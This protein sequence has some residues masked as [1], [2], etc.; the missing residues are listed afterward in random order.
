MTNSWTDLENAN[1]F[2][3]AGSNAAENHP[4][5]MKYL[6]RAQAKG[7]KIVVVDPRF[8]RT[9]AK[10]DLFAQI[11]PGTDIAYLGAIISYILENNRYDKEYLLNFTNASCR[12]NPNFA[13]NEGLFSGFD[14]SK[15]SYDMNTWGYVLDENGRPAKA[16]S[17]DESGTVFS[18]MKQ[19]FSRYTLETA[20]AISGIP[21]DT[22]RQIADIITK[23]GPGTIMYALG[24]TQHTTATQGIRCYAI[25]QLLLGNIGKCGG[26]VNALRG[27]PNVQGS[28][29]LSNLATTLPGYIP[30]PFDV[31]TDTSVYGQKYSST[32]RKHLISIL[33]AWFGDYATEANDYCYEYLPR[34]QSG[35]AITYI[36]MIEDMAR[37]QFKLLISTA[38]NPMVSV[39]NNEMVATG[40]SK[41][42][43]LV[44]LELFET[45]TAAFW[46][47]PNVKPEEIQTEVICLPAAFLYEKAGSFTNSGRWIQWKTAPLKPEGSAHSDLDIFTMIFR[48]VRELYADSTDPKDLPILRA[49]WDY[50][51]E[52]DPAKVLQE[53]NG[54]NVKSGKLIASLGEYLA[55]PIGE[56]S[57]GCWI[58]S[59]V[60]GSGNL[61]ARR[62]GEDPSGL[63]LFPGWTYSWPGN[64]RILYNRASCDAQGRP[65]DAKHQL[66]AWDTVK[67]QWGGN[68]IPDVI[69]RTKG[70]DTPEGKPAFR[71]TAEQMG[72]LFT[73]PYANKP[74]GAA[75]PTV[76]SGTTPDGPL[77]EFYEPMES[78]TGN[79]LHPKVAT[80]PVAQARRGLKDKPD[81]GGSDQFPYV[82]T[83]YTDGCEHF[84]SGSLSRNLPWLVECMPEAFLEIGDVLAKKLGIKNGEIV[85][86]LSARNSLQVMAMVTERI[87]PLLINGKE[88]HTV[89]MP[90]GWGFA[91]LATG[92]SVNSLTHGALDPAAGTPEYKAQLVNVR[93]VR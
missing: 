74:V 53:I 48:K 75:M 65:L 33:K 25:I 27:E 90:Y 24:M 7:A 91:G 1:W 84:C 28:T 80:N 18:L 93:K 58:Y 89:G 46:K 63:G 81:L 29:D 3:V 66:I 45:E 40:L 50:G 39:P 92:P 72:R 62:G 56:V 83:S 9:A 30:T 82:L 68:D 71:M 79:I 32:Y 64:I 11:R 70:P 51:E 76:V 55:A 22:I 41:L 49:S 5:A 67:G 19:H 88:T 44:N 36:P 57:C 38:I 34:M 78:P 77:P 10:A 14:S 20:A 52:P 69:D 16:A 21:A 61:A 73:A 2:L 12:I 54:Y 26:G 42:D 4:I 23:Q 47:A 37:G 8:T 31:D 6:M 17:L 13:F 15:T 87:Q 86:L 85:E 43:L 59:G 35:K 60:Y